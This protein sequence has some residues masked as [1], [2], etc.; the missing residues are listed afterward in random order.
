MDRIKSKPWERYKEIKKR[1]FTHREITNMIVNCHA[2]IETKCLFAI[3]YLTGSR[4]VEVVKYQYGG[5]YRDLFPKVKCT[6]I[7]LKDLN[8]RMY[9]MD[10]ENGYLKV[11]EIKTRVLKCNRISGKKLKLREEN[12]EEFIRIKRSAIV[13]MPEKTVSLV[14]GKGDDLLIELIE[15]YI[16]SEKRFWN[17]T[18]ECYNVNEPLFLKSKTWYANMCY[19]YL[20][21]SPHELRNIRSKMLIMERGYNLSLLQQVHGWRGPSM[22][23]LYS[24]ATGIDILHHELNRQNSIF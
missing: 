17:P 2:S 5:N 11:L 7:Q 23:A 18:L 15:Q 1:T 12:P 22:P 14:E 4:L 13:N 21:F 10:N 6:S 20:D 16:D 3:I 19:K 9:P 24:K 8:V